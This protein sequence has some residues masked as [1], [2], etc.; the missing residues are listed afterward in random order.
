MSE[1]TESVSE[2]PKYLG[3][4]V[5]QQVAN[6]NRKSGAT[7]KWWHVPIVVDG[8][9]QDIL[10]PGHAFQAALVVAGQQSEDLPIR[11]ASDPAYLANLVWWLAGLAS[12][13]GLAW[14]V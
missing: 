4:G 3:P 12:G 13:L 10:M 7:E 1:T 5:A 11:P 9:A 14:L 8:R 6:R 2:T